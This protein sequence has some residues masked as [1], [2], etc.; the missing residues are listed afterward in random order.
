M[1]RRFQA[2]LK[3]E[4][5]ATP[6]VW[7][8]RQAG[9]Y[10]KHYQGLRSK[11]DFIT[12]CKDPVLASEVALG[13]VLDFDFDVSILFS[14]LLFPLEVFG[15]G[16]TYDPGP[17]LSYSLDAEALRRFKDEGEAIKG[18][19]FQYEAMKLTREKL[20]AN[21]SLIGFVGGPWTLFTYAVEGAHKGGLETSKRNLPLYRQFLERMVPLLKLNIELQLRGGAE[22]VMVFDTSA[23]ELDPEI[24]TEI[25]AP[26]LKE[27]TRAFPGKVGYYARGIQAAHLR[28]H[29]FRSEELAGCG[30]DHR[31]DLREVMTGERLTHGFIQGNFDQSLLFLPP[32]Q[33]EERALRYLRAIRDTSEHDRRG[34]VAGLGHGVLPGTPEENVRRYVQLVREVF[35]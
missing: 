5:Q 34:W 32:D 10:H 23:G 17:K 22:V 1:N 28:D 14:D 12:L 8:M 21:K 20:P 18:L 35:K 25:V 33:F 9:R 31:W 11:N 30:F 19:Q 15:M 6:P 3:G 27:L 26:S 29:V 4:S 16:L 13:P 2:A 7:F 24:F